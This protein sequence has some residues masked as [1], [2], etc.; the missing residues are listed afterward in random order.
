MKK[1]VLMMMVVLLVGNGLKAQK[2]DSTTN[3]PDINQIDTVGLIKPEF[4]GGLDGWKWYI[5]RNFDYDIIHNFPKDKL[6]QTAEI[7]FMVDTLGKLSEIEVTNA[8]E[9][10]PPFVKEAIRFM[11]KSPNWIPAT[12]NG[13]KIICRAYKEINLI[14][15]P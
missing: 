6:K 7:T 9:I 4:P 15:Q 11:K 5:M 1:I 10:D 14:A 12:K 8:N 2:R 3:Q 13:N